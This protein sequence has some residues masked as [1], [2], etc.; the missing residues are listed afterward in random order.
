MTLLSKIK[1][2]NIDSEW[3][4]LQTKYYYGVARLCNARRLN[5]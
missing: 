4:T 3:H 1:V 2:A 5:H